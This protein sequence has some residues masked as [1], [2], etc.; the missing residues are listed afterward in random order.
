MPKMREEVF[1]QVFRAGAVRSVTLCMRNGHASIQ[2]VTGEGVTGC[3]HTKRGDMKLYRTDTAL[4]FLRDLGLSSVT[5][6]M[7]AWTPGQASLHV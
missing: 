1:A 6:D 5:V 2:Y 4:R 3:I 7:S